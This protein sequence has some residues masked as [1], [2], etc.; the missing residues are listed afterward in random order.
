MTPSPFEV[1]RFRSVGDAVA[2][3]LNV[4]SSP[5]CRVT[6]GRTTL[7]FR[8]IGAS[9]WP[10]AEQMRFALQV[11]SVARTVLAEDSRSKLRRGATR[12]ITVAFRD[13]TVIE[14]REVMARWECTVPDQR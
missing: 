4:E 1:F 9:R 8:Q 2:R 6:N 10:E 5:E 13:T 7:T 12:A 3:A 14:G 11:A